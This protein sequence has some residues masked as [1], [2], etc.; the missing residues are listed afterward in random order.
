MAAFTGRASRQQVDLR[1]TFYR[2]AKYIGILAAVALAV[3]FLF[4]DTVV[5]N[6]DQMAPALI[7]GDRILLLRTPFIW[8]L[9]NVY[10]SGLGAPV[11]FAHPLARGALLCLRVAGLPGDS[12]TAGKG[13][14]RIT[15]KPS[16]RFGTAMTDEETLPPAYSPR[17]SMSAYRI[18]VAGDTIDLDSMPLRDFF[19]AAAIIKQ[20]NS[21]KSLR[22]RPLLY[23]D[24]KPAQTFVLSDFVLFKGALD[25]I[26]PRFDFDWF[27]W[28]RL[29]QYC[30]QALKGKDFWL[31]L[32]IFDGTVRM[33]TYR[34]KKSCIFLLAD[35]WRKGFDS[36]YFGPVPVKS[37]RGR[38]L[39]VL[40]SWAQ[41]GHWIGA[42]RM[43]RLIKLVK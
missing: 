10:T 3:K 11:V 20:E 15:N 35:D 27:F 2:S 26:P 16:V 40:W 25:T 21:L 23:I 33:T 28:D 31:D 14:L 38:P 30:T 34:V 32:G 18:P 19:F 41:T 29:R 8:P 43:G 24:G 17:D 5:I 7:P 4:L 22:V 6:T 36:R 9:N 37:I 39:C 42:L 13:V 12:V 1:V